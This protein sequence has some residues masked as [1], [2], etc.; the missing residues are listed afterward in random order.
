MEQISS[1]LTFHQECNLRPLDSSQIGGFTAEGR[2]MI[3]LCSCEG[4]ALPACKEDTILKPLECWFRIGGA[5]VTAQRKL[6]VE[7]MRSSWGGN[8]DSLHWVCKSIPRQID[9]WSS[10]NQWEESR[11]LNPSGQVYGWSIFKFVRYMQGFH[12]LK[13]LHNFCKSEMVSAKRCKFL[14]SK[15]ITSVKI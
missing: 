9:N 15:I 14:R 2:V 6:C 4:V 3:G 13:N 7:G 12:R 5:D 1:S 8:A 11:A 10:L